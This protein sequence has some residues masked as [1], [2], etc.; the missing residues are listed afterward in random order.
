LPFGRTSSVPAAGLQSFDPSSFVT[1]SWSV[2]RPSLSVGSVNGA[3]KL[4]SSPP[5]APAS[6]AAA[7]R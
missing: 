5:P 2:A 6:R 1:Q 4:P 7:D 3:L